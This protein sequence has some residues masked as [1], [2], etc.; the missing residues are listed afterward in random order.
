MMIQTLNCLFP[1]S[2]CPPSMITLCRISLEGRM[3]R[4]DISSLP[5]PSFP[6]CRLLLISAPLGAIYGRK[7][8]RERPHGLNSAGHDPSNL[9][10]LFVT[11]A[12]FFHPGGSRRAHKQSTTKI[13]RKKVQRRDTQTLARNVCGQGSRSFAIV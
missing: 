10:P 2:S 1:F 8:E 13:W 9:R 5:L 12:T 7:R 4:C 11:A 3:S 6:F